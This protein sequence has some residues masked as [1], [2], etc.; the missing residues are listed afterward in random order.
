MS[1]RVM[2]T[3][4]PIALIPVKRRCELCGGDINADG[5]CV[6]IPIMDHSASYVRVAR[7]G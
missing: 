6:L 5:K 3:D 2:R 7:Q 4:E 1:K